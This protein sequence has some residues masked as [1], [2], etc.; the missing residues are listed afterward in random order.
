MTIDQALAFVRAHG[1]VLASAKGDAPRLAEAIAG[2]PIAGSWWAHSQGR[3]IFNV[4]QA[5]THSD[6]VLV[7][8]L[9]DGKVTL[10]HRR[11]WPLL[12]RIADRFEPA[13]IARVSEEHLASGRHRTTEVPFPQWVPPDVLEAASAVDVEAAVALLGKWTAAAGPRTARRSRTP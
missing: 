8:R 11:L 1:I 9:I 6:E 2:E 12:V 7:C 4:L 5:V 3:R 10:V 13:R